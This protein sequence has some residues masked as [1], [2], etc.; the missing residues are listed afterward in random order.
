MIKLE[1]NLR[2]E[3]AKIANMKNSKF[4]KNIFDV[5]KMCFEKFFDDTER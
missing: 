4:R 5:R 1:L 3:D 2:D